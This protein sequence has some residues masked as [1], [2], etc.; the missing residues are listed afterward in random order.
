M[1]IPLIQIKENHLSGCLVKGSVNEFSESIDFRKIN[2]FLN[3][4]NFDEII[5]NSSLFFSLF[6]K[7]FIENK[8]YHEHFSVSSFNNQISEIRTPIVTLNGLKSLI[9]IVRGKICTSI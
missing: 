8:L 1:L 9:E 6:C 5:N 2:D 3:T 4:K 7:S